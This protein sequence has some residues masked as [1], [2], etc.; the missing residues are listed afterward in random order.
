MRLPF[1]KGGL[2]KTPEI[3]FRPPT[4]IPIGN[5]LA[6][7]KNRENFRFFLYMTITTS[8]Q[9]SICVETALHRNERRTVKYPQPVVSK[10]LILSERANPGWRGSN[11]SRTRVYGQRGAT[12]ATSLIINHLRCNIW[13]N[14]GATGAQHFAP[15]CCITEKLAKFSQLF[16]SS[17]SPRSGEGVRSVIASMAL[18]ISIV[19][20]QC[21]S[22]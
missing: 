5:V 20:I 7:V 19:V 16:R 21:V 6:R 15:F 12:G 11:P 10:V 13:R 1:G 17:L 2:P 18:D 14:I 8:C 22:P 4:T 3:F 9:Q